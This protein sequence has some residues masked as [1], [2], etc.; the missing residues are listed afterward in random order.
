M[1][2]LLV[3]WLTRRSR[4]PRSLRLA[5]AMVLGAIAVVGLAAPSS[6]GQTGAASA[7][8]G[9]AA[10][11]N[12]PTKSPEPPGPGNPTKTF[13]DWPA[14]RAEGETLYESSCSSCHGIALQGIP[15]VAPSLRAVGPGPV[16]FYLSTGRLPLDQPRAEPLRNSPAFNRAQIDALIAF[17]SSFGGP[18]APT[19]DPSAG[20]LAVGFHEFT[21]NC[22][23]CH[24]IVPAA[25]SPSTRWF[26][27]FSKPHRS[28]SPRRYGWART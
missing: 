11:F 13:P 14:L 26:P 19:A 22:A 18:P 23:G 10:E 2:R 15:G 28:R 4:V 7:T 8:G 24:Q 21:L 6:R 9:P 20:N 12:P 27:T 17:I 5:L 3:R 25:G 16:D 1:R